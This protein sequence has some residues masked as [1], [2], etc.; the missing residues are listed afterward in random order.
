MDENGDDASVS[1]SSDVFLQT[2]SEFI[3]RNHVNYLVS[4]QQHMMCRFEKTNEMLLNFNVLSENRYQASVNEFKKHTQLLTD[5]KKDLDTV[6]KRI[7]VLK[8]TLSKQYPDSFAV[9][10]DVYVMPPEEAEFSTTASGGEELED[11]QQTV[12]DPETPKTPKILPD[13]TTEGALLFPDVT[14]D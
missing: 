4:T 3:D 7:R 10:S 6:F 11:D 2:L 9:C 5:M 1:N 8:Q 13:G 14:S 12:V